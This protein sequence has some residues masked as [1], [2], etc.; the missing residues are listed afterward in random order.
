MNR[1]DFFNKV[2]RL[3]LFA[4]LMLIIWFLARRI[5]CGNN[6]SGCPVYGS[7]RGDFKNPAL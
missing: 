1:G 2:M 6:C 3:A 7:C 4:A 5:I